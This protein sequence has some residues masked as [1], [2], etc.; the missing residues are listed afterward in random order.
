MLPSGPSLVSAQ[1]NPDLELLTL[2]WSQACAA[3]TLSAGQ[4]VVRNGAGEVLATS[5]ADS[6]AASATWN[7]TA[8]PTSVDQTSGTVAYLGS[9]SLQVVGSPGGVA[10]Q[11]FTGAACPVV[12]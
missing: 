5:S 10:V 4:F 3:A 8:V 2:Q 11:P 7:L 12:F 6:M 1:Y 9:P